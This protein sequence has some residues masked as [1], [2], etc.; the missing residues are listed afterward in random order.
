MDCRNAL[1]TEGGVTMQIKNF[2]NGHYCGLTDE[3]EKAVFITE[4]IAFMYEIT[5][6]KADVISQLTAEKDNLQVKVNRA[7]ELIEEAKNEA[8]R[9]KKV[10]IGETKRKLQIT[11]DRI[12]AIA[13]TSTVLGMQINQADDKSVMIDSL[14]N[15]IASVGIVVRELSDIGLWDSEEDK[16]V[17]TPV[18]IEN[19]INKKPIKKVAG[20]TISK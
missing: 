6:Q 17:I 10:T 4:V 3:K 13:S 15:I 8:V 19:G 18:V 14:N 11:R 7:T 20:M 5:M 9:V 1:A 16:P 2:L 12:V